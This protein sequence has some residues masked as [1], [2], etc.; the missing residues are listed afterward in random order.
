[1][2]HNYAV[3]DWRQDDVTKFLMKQLE[4]AKQEA[5]NQMTNFGTEVE[6]L[7]NKYHYYRGVI[8]ALN[9]A[10]NLDIE[11]TYESDV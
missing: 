6:N 8:S 9:M 4:E 10:L 1:M 5:I 2:I 7:S 3:R 11:D